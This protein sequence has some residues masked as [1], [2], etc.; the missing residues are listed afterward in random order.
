LSTKYV[1]T[2]TEEERRQLVNLTTVGTSAARRLLRA[3]IL[4]K[5]DAAEGG[6]N[7]PDPAISEA[8][9]VSL[10]TIHRT[11]QEFVEE[12]VEAA[13]N[14]KKPRLRRSQVLD[15]EQE[16]HLIALAC[17]TPPPGRKGWTLQLLADQ[18]VELGYC[19][20]ISDETVRRTLKKTNSSH[21]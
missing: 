12:G 3:R 8:L 4:L 7:W 6:A 17:S 20:M 13:L 18:L 9:D 21:G 16:A 11:R 1:V 10:P 19:E 2:L 5:A 15:G 14:R